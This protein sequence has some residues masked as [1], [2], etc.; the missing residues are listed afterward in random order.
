MPL[1]PAKRGIK[2]WLCADFTTHNVSAFQVYTERP[3]Q[4]K[5]ECGLGAPVVTELS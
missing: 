1:K 3:R 4:G 2:V 5:P